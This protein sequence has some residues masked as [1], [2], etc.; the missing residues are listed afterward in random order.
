MEKNSSQKK[1][2]SNRRNA[3]KSTGPKTAEGKKAVR[4]NALKHGLLTKEVVLPNS[5]SGETKAEFQ[6]LL[7]QL[8]ED[9]RPEG[10]LEEMLVEKIAI[11][12]WRL[13]RAIRCEVGEIRSAQT[14]TSLM[15]QFEDQWN[16]D[17]SEFPNESQALEDSST[18]LEETDESTLPL[19]QE[20]DNT[21][22]TEVDMYKTVLEES[23][24]AM[25]ALR[26]NVWQVMEKI[27]DSY[28]V[29]LINSLPSKEA[30]D[31][32]I[33]YETAIERQLY[34]AISELERLQRRRRSEV[35]PP[36]IN[37]EV[38]REELSC[39]TNPNL[40]SPHPGWKFAVVI[41]CDQTLSRFLSLQRNGRQTSYL[42]A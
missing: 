33:R 38:S 39:D 2:E 3:L 17:M 5:E 27:D 31:K 29:P 11:C 35:A 12:Y 42:A 15:K 41:W 9:L 26:S 7:G 23:R 40:V 37:V 8:C 25:K 1:I 30:V 16:I 14:G 21:R 4:W 10:V 22:N 18:K 20:L 34:R 36:T 28:N 19:I 13:R 24:D 32:I 6:E